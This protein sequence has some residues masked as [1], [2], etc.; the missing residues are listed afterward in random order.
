MPETRSHTKEIFSHTITYGL[1]LVLNRSLSFLLIPLYTNFFTPEE[2]GMYSLIFSFWL[3]L[4]IIY[5]YGLET[6]FIKFFID[7][8]SENGRK[9]IYSSTLF[10]LA[11][12]SIL[13]STLFF[14]FSENISSL[15]DFENPSK[16]LFL[17]KLTSLIIIF[18]I[19]HRF[20]LL[21]F[22]AEL[23]AKKYLYLTLLSV[24]TNLAANLILIL[25]FKLSIEAVFY[26]YLISIVL[27]LAAGL[28]LT[29]KYLSFK[30][31]FSKIREL[32]IYGN[33]F[34]YIGIF[35]TIID[36]SDRFFLKYFYDE[37]AVGIYSAN[38]R[39]GTIMALIIS[40]F[41]FSWT[42]YFLN[43]SDNP[44]NKKIISNIFTYF[45][46][47]GLLL[48]LIF[49]FFLEPAAKIS[50]FGLSILDERYWA[51]LSIIPVILLSYF[52]SGLYST[53]N[54]AP[55]FTDRTSTLLYISLAGFALNIF[56]NFLLIPIL[57]IQGAAYSTLFTYAAMFFL[58][59]ITTQKI[60]K[61]E[62]E[63][64]KV[65]LTAV[66]TILIFIVHLFLKNIFSES[67]IIQLAS[68]TLIAL[69]LTA[70]TY[71]RIVNLKNLKILFKK[72]G[73]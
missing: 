30:V 6:S 53:L 21:L 13:F 19:L 63:W 52:F 59:Y 11:L 64:N 34:I 33:K 62:Y 73:T 20:P 25:I 67:Y 57:G 26:S 17:I 7:E 69:F 8:K 16:G 40:A 65:F 70:A 55:F 38:Y 2:M 60:Y 42:P 61:I 23:K 41:K 15:I 54:A 56:F 14:L 46:F 31:S 50:L 27:T 1:G 18:D 32:V 37:D 10:I 71:F 43:L 4:N 3:F 58:I 36:I 72:T 28:V 47:T 49:S 39:L 68:L 45:V 44:D 29:R 5:V 35:I 22:R 51:G 24:I 48:F 9:E 12:T 66:L